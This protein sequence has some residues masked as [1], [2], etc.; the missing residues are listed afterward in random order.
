MARCGCSTDCLCTLI[1]GDCTVVVGSGTITAPYS[2]SVVSDPDILNQIECRDTGLFIEP[3]IQVLSGNCIE[4][5]GDGTVADPLAAEAII[6]A[7][8]ANLVECTVGGLEAILNTLNGSCVQLSGAGT[9]GDPLTPELTVSIDPGNTLE[10]RPNGAFVP[11]TGLGTMCRATIEMIA[12]QIIPPSAGAGLESSSPIFYD[13]SFFPDACGYIDNGP[14]TLRFIV[15]VGFDG[16]HL[17]TMQE[18]D[19]GLTGQNFGVNC[20]GAGTCGGTDVSAG[21]QIR[22]NGITVASQLFDRVVDRQK[23]WNCSRAIDLVPGDIVEGYFGIASN[24]G[25]TTPH[26]LIGGVPGFP[27]FLQ[28]TRLSA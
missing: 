27:R 16:L 17:I 5:T 14:G 11:V 23:S 3:L 15:P 9:A 25:P 6:S 10:C 2:T 4:L 12:P 18:R 13:S 20:G 8:I 26:T 7:D 24:A 19:N 21:I 28:I 1:D 22:V